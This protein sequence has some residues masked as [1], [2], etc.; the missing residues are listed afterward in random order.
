MDS[1]LKEEAQYDLVLEFVR[2]H[3]RIHPMMGTRKLLE[4]IREDTEKLGISIGRDRLFGLLR[5][6]GLLVKR[7]KKYVV[8]TQS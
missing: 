3:R 6:E 7:K 2:D 5:S 4:L 1:K 8:T